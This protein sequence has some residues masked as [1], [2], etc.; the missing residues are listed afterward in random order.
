MCV[1]VCVFILIQLV[2]G[3][4]CHHGNRL[5][6]LTIF[7]ISVEFSFPSLDSIGSDLFSLRGVFL[8]NL[9]EGIFP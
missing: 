1:C 9:I 2:E 4:A 5:F 6:V 7:R 8:L 3:I